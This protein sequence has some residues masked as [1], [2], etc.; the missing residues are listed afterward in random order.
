MYRSPNILGVIKSTRLRWAGHVA[1][2]GEGRSAFKML[3]GKPTG[4]RP[5]KRSR[6]IW[7]DNIRMYFKEIDINTRNRVYMAQDKDYWRALVNSALNLRV[8]KPWS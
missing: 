3:T 4:M 1:R 8:H 7:E 2:R 5:L 6:R